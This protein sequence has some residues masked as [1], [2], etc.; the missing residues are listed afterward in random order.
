MNKELL[1]YINEPR[2]ERNNTAREQR[3]IDEISRIFLEEDDL[4]IYFR[5]YDKSLEKNQS[6]D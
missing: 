5:E 1:D 2:N 3:I 6:S 4:D